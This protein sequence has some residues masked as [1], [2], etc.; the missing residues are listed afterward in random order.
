MSECDF[1][2]GCIFFNDKMETKSNLASMYKRKYCQD[3]YGNCARYM[4]ATT[5]GRE[6][7]PSDMFPNMRDKAEEIISEN[8]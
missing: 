2:K 1:I 7:V 8:N 4:V 3:N 5:V 6:K